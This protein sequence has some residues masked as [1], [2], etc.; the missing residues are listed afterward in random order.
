LEITADKVKNISKLFSLENKVALVTGATGGLGHGIA[1]AYAGAGADVVVSD[2]NAERT[3]ELA[4]EIEKTGRRALAVPADATDPADV[5]RVV[6]AAIEKFG[7]I[8]I[9]FNALG[10]LIL[11][12][13]IDY[14]V[15][16]WEKMVKVNLES[17]FLFC[18]AVGR[19]MIA[20][21][22]GKVVSI[23]SVRG[24]QGRA[25]DPA[26]GPCKAAVNHLMRTLGVEWAPYHITCNSIAPTFIRTELNAWQLDDQAFYDKVVS[27]IPMGRLGAI[28]DLFGAAI[29]LASDASNF[30]TGMTVYVDGGWTVA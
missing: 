7:R 22:Y 4:A 10:M 20:Q 15:S 21:D 13:T 19:V 5:D 28:D 26:Y 9:L 25:D 18:R 17:I 30:I 2:L 12:P 8:D 11:K 23:S 6:A 1:L 3:H 29:F 16:D 27:R 14:V 24:L